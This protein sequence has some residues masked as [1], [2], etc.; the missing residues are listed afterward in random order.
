MDKPIN[1]NGDL[2]IP[3]KVIGS[4]LI[5][6][7][8]REYG[9]HTVNLLFPSPI[10]GLKTVHRRILWT[11]NNLYP[12][13]KV[14][15]NALVG[16]VSKIHP[17]GDAST[18]ES[19]VR[20]SQ[21]FKL[22][23]PLLEVLG[24]NGTYG[25]DKYGAQRYVGFKISEFAKD[26]FFS[27]IDKRCYHMVIGDTPNTLE[28]EH[29]IPKLPYALLSA[30]CTPGF[31]TKSLTVGYNLEGIIRLVKDYSL[32]HERCGELVSW[33]YSNSIKYLMPHSPIDTILRN[34]SMLKEEMSQ[35]RF[36]HRI[37]S[38]GEMAIFPDHIEIYTL[39]IGLGINKCKDD[40]IAE[41]QKKGSYFEQNLTDYRSLSS[42]KLHAVLKLKFK[43]N[44][45][46]FEAL[47]EVK[48]VTK[49]TGYITPT[50]NYSTKGTIIKLSPPQLLR[51]WYRERYKS[52]LAKKKY[53]QMSYSKKL[54]ELELRLMV[55][56]QIDKVIKIIRNNDVP[57]GMSLLKKEFDLTNH[58]AHTLMGIPLSN[59]AKSSKIELEENRAKIKEANKQL[60]V[61]YK[62]VD[63][64]I[65]NEVEALGKKYKTS[66]GTRIPKYMGYVKIGDQ[67]I[68]QYESDKELG[69][70]LDRFSNSN[71]EQYKK[72]DRYFELV[73]TTK[74]VG[75]VPGTQLPKIVNGQRILHT[76]R[77][78]DLKTVY[79]KHGEL[80]YVNKLIFA[81]DPELRL[82]L[83]GEN[84]ITITNKGV[85]VRQPIT[86]LSEK[87]TLCKGPISD[88]IFVC[89]DTKEDLI[90][91][92]MNSSVPNQVRLQLIKSGDK[93]LVV[94][95]AGKTTI[96]GAYKASEYDDIYLTLEKD[97]ISRTKIQHVKITKPFELF[98]KDSY[99]VLD[100]NKSTTNKR[101]IKKLNQTKTFISI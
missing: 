7:N 26:V 34:S 20:L 73:S 23:H 54:Q 14:S 89:D 86:N 63:Q 24:D 95:M 32:H 59:L 25:G 21:T 10:D 35:G 19:I 28:P 98:S 83:V 11:I 68:Y 51:Y 57:T 30:N 49:F 62:K 76:T 99:V 69:N 45:D 1:E 74:N 50:N 53:Q 55:S 90:V 78:R 44:I 97:C 43:R 66:N 12:D 93:Q 15:G 29:L 6:D 87:K 37:I 36:E 84:I 91:V 101:R 58:Q 70:L 48:R 3:T 52:I 56:H 96:L 82:F 72:K 81:A 13:E 18:Y 75:V 42:Q 38:D 88:I 40:I 80:A 33:N 9:I 77:Q 39:P 5:E 27:N 31:G 16:D 8:A 17:Y 47:N 100:I 2:A 64:E 94:T 85:I 71:I 79:S 41:M 4:Q 92:S 46:I 61:S 67:G 22:S 65:Y 60:I